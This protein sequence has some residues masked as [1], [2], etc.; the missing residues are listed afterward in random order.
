M[1]IDNSE[2]SAILLTAEQT[3]DLWRESLARG[4][5]IRF[6]VASG[7]MRPALV[8]DDIVVVSRYAPPTAPRVGDIV[9]FYFGERWIVH[10]IVGKTSVDGQLFFWQKGDDEHHSVMTPAAAVAGRVVAIENDGGRM[11]FDTLRQRIVNRLFGAILAA[12]DRLLRVYH[13]MGK[14]GR[15]RGERASGRRVMASGC[16]RKTRAIVVKIGSRLMRGGSRS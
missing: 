12:L 10:R 9:L 2:D 3:D 16:F 7:S 4:K 14:G 5:A 13:G 11:D 6:R 15:K 1:E 8:Q